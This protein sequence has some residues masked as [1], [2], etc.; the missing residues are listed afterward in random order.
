MKKP[1]VAISV[2]VVVVV[3]A[4]GFLLKPVNAQTINLNSIA[5]KAELQNTLAKINLDMQT[6]KASFVT[7]TDLQN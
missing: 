1:V 2:V 4:I 5:T 7:K 3:I 6:L